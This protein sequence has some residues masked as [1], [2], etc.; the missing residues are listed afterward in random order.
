MVDLTRIQSC[1]TV[2]ANVTLG[3]NCSQFQRHSLARAYRRA[4][5]NAPLLMDGI[6]DGI[7]C[8]GADGAGFING[9]FDYSR[10][11]LMSDRGKS[12]AI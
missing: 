8:E 5:P 3:A 4:N 7:A 11:I 10:S 1:A 12:L 9:P 2:G 6:R